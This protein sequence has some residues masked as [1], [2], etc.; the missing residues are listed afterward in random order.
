[1]ARWPRRKWT[2]IVTYLLVLIGFPLCCWL[3]YWWVR[4][5]SPF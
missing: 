5:P 3:A 4:R 1:M 2:T